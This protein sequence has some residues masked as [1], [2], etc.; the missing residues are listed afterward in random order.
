MTPFYQHL[1]GFPG[2]GL[3]SNV[4]KVGAWATAGVAAA[5]AAHGFVQLGKR[6][7]HKDDERAAAAPATEQ[8]GDAA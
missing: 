1:S 6:Y 7:L 5:F 3:H 4:D 8:K 2:F